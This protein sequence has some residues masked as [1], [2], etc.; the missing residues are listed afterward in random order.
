MGGCHLKGM[1][2]GT[3]QRVGALIIKPGLA[4][5][6]SGRQLDG[7]LDSAVAASE[8]GSKVFAC[9]VFYAL[10]SRVALLSYTA[11]FTVVRVS[12]SQGA[13]RLASTP[14]ERCPRRPGLT[15]QALTFSL[16][17]CHLKGDRNPHG[18]SRSAM[19]AALLKVAAGPP[20]P[21]S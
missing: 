15:R 1:E 20:S 19:A 10:S 8:A 18:P 17:A 7:E 2:S 9:F 3:G 5:R 16:P 12:E 11:L 21:A 6:M 13:L 14:G 4:Y